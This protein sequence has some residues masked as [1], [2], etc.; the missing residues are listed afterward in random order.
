MIDVQISPN[1]SRGDR[2]GGFLLEFYDGFRSPFW[3]IELGPEC[4]IDNRY[5]YVVFSDNLSSML[6]VLARDAEAFLLSARGLLPR[7]C[8]RGFT[9]VTQPISTF[10]GC[11]FAFEDVT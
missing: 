9:G 7:L 11:K 2:A 4:L 10:Q 5:E 8:S 3:A 1:I 6:F